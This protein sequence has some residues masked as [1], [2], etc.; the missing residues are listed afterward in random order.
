MKYPKLLLLVFIAGLVFGCRNGKN[1]QPVIKD[2]TITKATSFNEVFFDSVQLASFLNQNKQLNLFAE[3]YGDFYKSRN[4]QFAWFDSLGITQQ[5]RD[6]I[7][8]LQTTVD[9]LQDSSLLNKSFLNI[10]D[11]VLKNEGY[12]TKQESINMELELTGQF[13]LFASKVYKG[14]D[15]DAASLGWF[16]PRKKVNLKELLLTTLKIDSANAAQYEPLNPQYKKLQSTLGLYRSLAKQ[17]QWNLLSPPI[18][19]LKKGDSATLISSIKKRLQL[20]GDAATIDTSSSYDSNLLIAVKLFQQRIGLEPDGVIGK[21]MIDELNISPTKRIEQILL[22]LERI[23]WMPRQNESNYILVNIPEF[24]MHVFD[25]GKQQLEM[26]VIVGTAANNTVIFTGNL[27]YIMFSPYW[28]VPESIVSK[29]IMPSMKRNANYIANKDME[30]TGYSNGL[31]MVRQKPGAGNSLGLVKFLFPN[32]HSI[33]LH[34]TP[35][36]NLFSESSRSFSHGCIRLAEAKKFAQYL[37]RADTA[38]IW[39]SNIIDSSMHLSKERWVTLPK[40]IP[41]LIAY[42][43][44]WVDA[45]GKLN[46]RKDIYKHDEKLA[47]KLFTR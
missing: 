42:F 22:N 3:Q 4:Y 2:S 16:I 38:T 44:A 10:K 11:K 15:L 34:D 29:E 14:S 37:L 18:K 19:S 17:H 13:F 26:N 35:N 45:N 46:F 8:L 25:N 20:L 6:F 39:K 12:Y 33:Y 28:N 32:S 30:I 24:K 7:N 31:P 43:T 5:T 41:V 23:R 40:K 47:A 27:Q 36:K 9:D 21:K 1:K